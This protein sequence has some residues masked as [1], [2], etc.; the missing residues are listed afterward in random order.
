MKAP[1]GLTR[2]VDTLGRAVWLYLALLAAASR[3]GVIL[4]TRANLETTLGVEAAEIDDW[5]ARLVSAKLVRVESSSGNFLAVRVASWPGSATT[6]SG[7]PVENAPQRSPSVDKGPVYGHC[8]AE[9]IALGD[10][11]PGD[12]GQGEGGLRSA[13]GSVL[14][15][16]DPGEIDRILDHY[17][18][19]VLRRALHRVERAGRIRKSK[20]ALFRYLL[21]QF[22]QSTHANNP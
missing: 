22:S 14:T 17:P 6:P 7:S 19:T 8:S 3:E 16:A 2:P 10:K 9:A 12:R 1:L 18:A 21:G 11:S 20:A 5:L 13:I 4:R 15:N